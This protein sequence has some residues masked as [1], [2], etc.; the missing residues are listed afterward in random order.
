MQVKRRCAFLLTIVMIVSV[1][2]G[3]PMKGTIVNA[4]SAECQG[5][6]V[7]CANATNI[8]VT[9]EDSVISYNS[10]TKAL[11]IN[12]S[13]P[14]TLS[15]TATY[16]ELYIYIGGDNAHDVNLTLSDFKIVNSTA[17]LPGIMI[18]DN[19]KG[20][21]N[22]TLEGKN[23]IQC[24]KGGGI[25]KN[26]DNTSGKLTIK[27]DGSLAI[28]NAGTA[29]GIGGASGYDAANIEIKSG[30]VEVYS[31]STAAAI[32]GGANGDGRYIT[33]SGGTVNAYIAYSGA[34][35][36]QYGAAIGGGAYGN[37]ENITISGGNVTARSIEVDDTDYNTYKNYLISS[38]RDKSIDGGAGIGGGYGANGTNIVIS[39]GNVNAIGDKQSAGI[40]SGNSDGSKTNTDI[41]ISG[42]YIVATSKGGY[43]PGIGSGMKESTNTKTSVNVTIT[44][45]TTKATGALQAVGIGASQRADVNVYISGGSIFAKAGTTEVDG[46]L[47]QNVGIG[48][49]SLAENASSSTEI[50]S[51][52]LVHSKDNLEDV[53]VRPLSG[54][55]PNTEVSPS[56]TYNNEPYNDYNSKGMVADENGFIYPYLIEGV[57]VLGPN[58]CTV[59]FDVVFKKDGSLSSSSRTVKLINANNSSISVD[60]TTTDNATYN[61]SGILTKGT[62]NLNVDGTVVKQVAI[63]GQTYDDI[64]ID[65]FSVLVEDVTNGMVTAESEAKG[66]ED[67]KFSVSPDINYSIKQVSYKIGAGEYQTL[68]GSYGM[69]TI[70]ASAI[71][72]KI[73]IKAE[74]VEYKGIQIDMSGATWNYNGPYSYKNAPYTVQ[75]SSSLPTGV[76]SV[77]YTNNEKSDIGTYTAIAE[78]TC[79]SG[80]YADPI[81]CTWEIAE[82]KPSI[83]LKYNGSTTENEWYNDTI[84]VTE[85]NHLI[86]ESANATEFL[87]S[88]E[89]NKGET[90]TL[91]FKNKTTGCVTTAGQA[92]SVNI[93]DVS[94]TGKIEIDGVSYNTLNS[95]E[96]KTCHLEDTQFNITSSD[97]DS[98]V[99]KVEYATADQ[100]LITA[101]AVENASLNWKTGTPAFVS[102]KALYV[103]ITDNAGNKAYISTPVIVND[104]QPPTM[105][106]TIS[107]ITANSADYNIAFSESSNYAYMLIKD[108]DLAPT[109][110]EEVRNGGQTGIGTT[111]TG[112]FTG[113]IP[114]TKYR[115]YAVADDGMKTLSGDTNVNQTD[116][117]FLTSFT[118]AEESLDN[119]VFQYNGS[120]TLKDWYQGQVAISADG[121]YISDSLNGNFSDSY[122]ITSATSGKVSKTLYLKSKT[123]NTVISTGKLIEVNIDKT[124]P[125]GTITL[126]GKT[127]DS[128]NISDSKVCHLSTSDVSV[129]SLDN[130]SGV[131]KVEY[132]LSTRLL[133]EESDVTDSITSWKEGTPYFESGKAV[134]IRITDQ[135]G[136]ITYIST[137]VIIDDT[138]A[139]TIAMT[140]SAITSTSAQININ[141]TDNYVTD[142]NYAYVLLKATEPAPTSWDEVVALGKCGTSKG[143]VAD[144]FE[145]LEPNTKYILYAIAN[146]GLTRLDATINN[147]NY[148]SVQQVAFDT[149]KYSVTV[150]GQT[151]AVKS[152]VANSYTYD[153]QQILTASNVNISQMGTITYTAVAESGDILSVTGNMTVNGSELTIPVKSSFGSGKEQSIT[154]TIQSDNYED[155]KTVLT[156]KSVS[157]TPV[158]LEDVSVTDTTYNGAA[159]G[160]TGTIQWKNDG[161]VCNVTETIVEYEGIN[162]TTYGPSAVAPTNAGDY[163][164]TFTVDSSDANYAGTANYY[165]TISKA[166]LSGEMVNA[167]WY[168]GDKLLSNE[169]NSVIGNGQTYTVELKGYPD[170]VKPS[171]A[172]TYSA[173]EIGGY[174]AIANFTFV[175]DSYATNYKLPSSMN[176]YWKIVGKT[177]VSLTGVSVAD[178]VY[179]G[180]AHGYAGSIQWMDGDTE[181]NVANTSVEYVGVNNTTYGPS[182]DAPTNAGDYKVVFTAID[183]Q[184]EGTQSH[185][186]TIEK[187]NITDEMSNMAWYINGEQIAGYSKTVVWTGQDYTVEL[188]DYSDRLKVSYSGDCSESDLGNYE[189]VATFA[190]KDNSD[191]ANYNLPASLSLYWKISSKIQVSLSGV[192]ANNVTYNGATQGYTGTIQWK[193]GDEV[194]SVSDTSV[195]YTGIGT[196]T[197]GPS[198]EAPTNAGTY[199]VTFTANDN[200][201]EGTQSFWY[202]IAKADLN[203]EMTNTK[204]YA[205]DTE[206]TG[207]TVEIVEDGQEYTVEVKD[208]SDKVTPTYSGTCT[209]T[210]QG[211]YEAVVEFDFVDSAYADNYLLPDSMTLNWAIVDKYVPDMSKV[212][213]IYQQ[214]NT[215]ADYVADTTE[216]TA[217]GSNYT[218]AV[219]GL[220]EGVTAEYSGTCTAATAGTYTAT[221]TFKN[222][223]ASKYYDPS[224]N[225]MS[226]NWSIVLPTPSQG[227]TSQSIVPEV[228]TP[229]EIN[230]AKYVVTTAS[231]SGGTVNYNGP[232]DKTATSIT[233][234]ATVEIDGQVYAVTTISTNAFSGC[235]N[236]ITIVIP[237]GITTIEANAFKGCT[238][239]K[240]VTIPAS[241]TSIGA[242]AF[243]GCKAMTSV[244]LG[245][246]VTTIGANAFKGCIKL[247]SITIPASVTSIGSN[248]FNGCKVMTKATIGK[249]VKTIGT[250]AFSGCSKLKTVSIHSSSKLTNIGDKAFYKCVLLN[251]ITIPKNVTKIGKQAF[252]GC[253]KLR[254]ITIKSKKLKSVGSKAIKNIHKKA[255]IKCPGKTYVTK[256]KK[257][258]KSKTGYKKTM[259]IKK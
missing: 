8:D 177:Q 125:A 187:A 73:S 163:K 62:Y 54:Y 7:T 67:F 171:Y 104:T 47:S 232:I 81:S 256:Y 14:V 238:K 245:K 169:A 95:A 240:S 16:N 176:L 202:T 144:T 11:S 80:Y 231:A 237:E 120:S 134:Y 79:E 182:A 129:T 126:D 122:T 259:K 51:T 61:F 33:I 153:L 105:T 72:D 208:Y 220:P 75:I 115:I 91:Y 246:N 45:G 178:T 142:I 211:Q 148:T 200:K 89:L 124:K 86:A 35:N 198:E 224:P 213:W 170:K 255:T 13:E 127:Y 117:E 100:L 179:N 25:Q 239:L 258:F 244:K 160:Y 109:S 22:I 189:A 121:Y 184:Y 151:Y 199:K 96:E 166:D 219:T 140:T 41:T 108:V 63:E 9:D 162:G 93:D 71:T 253:K 17:A 98:E 12:T 152:G 43:G 147:P 248:A 21:V 217:N 92:V 55:T 38:Y 3:V 233:I 119:I 53:A 197:Y 44:G 26:G 161:Q 87:E 65:V 221:V 5:L 106:S 107:N 215:T 40:G 154:V 64:S 83:T 103:R 252:E 188:K 20:N 113:L 66:G 226:L 247:K 2:T 24:I 30:T 139:P 56:F 128:L 34:T 15:G 88:V 77:S 185:R 236:L 227:D 196:T 18:Q 204:W 84:I 116:V 69:Y 190:F 90:K 186:F 192:V 131:A 165:Y 52:V 132:A 175:D 157:K 243:S 242:N 1:L 39:G 111:A 229:K 234:P 19:Y 225:T 97:T 216:L 94:P 167:A 230:G 141:L 254:T 145:G 4:A 218:V 155:I 180:E 28:K 201:Y 249:N 158:T 193:D 223:N 60:A 172:G 118:T 164:V 173:T 183:D 136:N 110:V 194:C 37:G 99:A 27:G 114:N 149:P 203:S 138:Q 235:N 29:A 257:L 241:V 250:G 130:E 205:N 102:G 150:S 228:G 181:C 212:K 251:K 36:A 76:K 10:T 209:A 74:I 137:P 68:T 49:F 82:Y 85:D 31:H 159:Q 191:A 6:T 78:F 23:T 70:P 214:G 58:D 195:E 42:G 168:I 32:G 143:S 174:E 46:Y 59:D 133:T 57:S 48:G 112:S 206:I 135:V 101:E 156:V 123:W 207:D 222:A 146:D 210:D 50:Y